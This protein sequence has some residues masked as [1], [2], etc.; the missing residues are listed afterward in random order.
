M[1][2]ARGLDNGEHLANV[3]LSLLPYRLFLRIL[4]S[5]S[6]GFSIT[7]C[8][9]FLPA[10]GGGSLWWWGSGIIAHLAQDPHLPHNHARPDQKHPYILPLIISDLK[11]KFGIDIDI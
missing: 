6:P 10:Y 4:L 3:I 7:Q 11:I 5:S 8:A 9:C 2:S 1:L